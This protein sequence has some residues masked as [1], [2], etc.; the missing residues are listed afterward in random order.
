[1]QKVKYLILGA[2]ISGLTFASLKT[3]ND[4]LIIEKENTIGGLCKSFYSKNF[5]WDVAG[6]FFHFH[7]E[8]TK[9]Y[10]LE[11]TRRLKQRNV[12]K[13]A[14]VYYCGQ[15]MDAPFQYNIHQL[16]TEEF[17]ECLTNLYFAKGSE[18]AE[19]FEDYVKLK[20]GDGI[21]K[22][23]LI[24]YN[25]KLYACKMNELEKNSMGGFLPKLNFNSLMNYYRKGDKK[26]K[27]YNDTF[28]YPINGCM[29]VMN[30]LA[31]KIDRERINLNEKV[32]NIDVKNK[33]VITDKASYKYEYLINSIP[34]STFIECAEGKREKELKW[35]KVLVLNIGFDKPSIDKKVSWIYFPG[36]EVFYR[37]GFYNNIA[38]TSNLSIY[39]EIGYGKDEPIDIEYALKQTLS[40]L[41]KVGIIDAHIVETWQAYIIDPG[42]VHITVKGTT[43]V[44]NYIASMQEKGVNMIGRYARWEYSAM[45]DSFE[46]AF[47]LAKE[48]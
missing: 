48:I 23:F 15:M 19:N 27:T 5:V 46:Q 44:N 35:N 13:C 11:L 31:E 7:S 45:D 36:D 42:Y 41:R 16:K 9:A 28:L 37:V 12:E 24:P 4:Y 20:Y 6:H 8:E 34:L 3:G 18:Q 10:Y 25:E 26:E 47:K 2:G 43:F 29:E 40:D 38:A 17:I 32:C 39:V 14:K 33:I 1:M 21:S 30:A 22:K